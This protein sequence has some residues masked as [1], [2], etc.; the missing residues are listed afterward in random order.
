[1]T[2]TFYHA[3][4]FDNLISILERGI[5]PS[6]EGIV[7]LCETE[8]DAAKFVALRGCKDM[9]ICV[10]SLN[11]NDV[12]ETFDHSEAFF[13]CKCFGHTGT[14]KTSQILEFRRLKLSQ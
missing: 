12:H 14:I 10:V 3:T 8:Q 1:M 4:S 5:M 7:Y 11:E 6:F 9:L 13:K 2:K